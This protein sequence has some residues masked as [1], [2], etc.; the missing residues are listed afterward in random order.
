MSWIPPSTLEERIKRTL[1]PPR[2]ELARIVARELKKGEPEL[3]LA[4]LLTHR[5]RVAVDV[6]ANR[7]IWTHVLSGHASHVHAFEP[8]PKMFAVLNAARPANATAHAAALSDSDGSATL[9]VPHY[10]TGYSNQHASLEATRIGDHPFGEVEIT[11]LRLDGLEL[12]P[13]GFMKID[14]EG[15]ER[16]VLE[17]A[18]ATIARD[19]PNMVIELEER[20]TGEPIEH[21][22]DFVESL[23]YQTFVIKHGQLTRREAFN[24]DTDHRDAVETPS[25]VFNFVFL[26]L[27]GAA[28]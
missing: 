21:A 20:H 27:A 11:T 6:G 12:G 25:Y 7:G 13:I 17:G 4:P 3:K 26:P 23:G 10:G 2:L 5:D 16:A 15:H 19:R 14:V 22:L 24:P 28:P 1:I 8:N 9:K 18:R